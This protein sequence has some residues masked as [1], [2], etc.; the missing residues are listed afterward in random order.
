MKR[1]LCSPDGKSYCGRAEK[2]PDGTPCDKEKYCPFCWNALNDPQ[3]QRLWGLTSDDNGGKV[4][5]A[6]LPKKSGNCC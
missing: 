3:Y 5:V 1:P 2:V 4:D 6:A